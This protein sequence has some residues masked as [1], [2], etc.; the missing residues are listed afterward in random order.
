M[1]IQIKPVESKADW[2]AFIDFPWTIYKNDPVW[3][4]P[5]KIAVRDLLDVNKNPFFKHASMC[6]FLAFRDGK[7]VGRV[8]ALVDDNHNKVHNE[9]VGFFGF[10]ECIDDLKVAKQFNRFNSFSALNFYTN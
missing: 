8:I 7:A 1:K 6:P 4:P 2:S 9:K 3:V 5:L 10:F